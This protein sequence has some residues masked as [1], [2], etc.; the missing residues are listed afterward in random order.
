MAAGTVNISEK[1][2]SKALFR[3]LWPLIIE[4]ILAVTMGAADTVMVSS[5]GEFAVSGINIVDNI[6]NLLIITFTALATGGAVVVSQYI[7]R[8]DSQNASLASRQLVYIVTGISLVIMVFTVFLRRPIISLLYGKI[9]NDVMDAASIYFMITALSYPMLAIYNACAALFRAV[10]NSKVTMRIALL[11]NVMNIGG[12]AF[13]I[14]VL[15]IGVAGAAIS[16]LLCRTVAAAILMGMLIRN[17]R[18]TIT[19]AGLSKVRLIPSMVRNILNVGIPSGIESSMF[20]VGRLLTQRIFTTFGTMAMAANAIA[21]VINSFS[22]MPGTAYGIALL[23]VVG[24]CVGA[25]DY[26]A[27]R[28]QTAKIMKLCYFTIFIMSV[29]IYI[30]MEPLVNLFSLSQ[31]AHDLAKS[32]LRVHC[33][34]MAIGWS[35]SF[36]LPNALRAAGDAKYV[37]LAATVSMWTVRVSFAYILTFAVGLGPVGV[38]LAMGADFVSRGIAYLTR[39]L[40]RRWEGKKVIEDG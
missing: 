14:Y 16:T 4:Q 19:L 2:D 3:L 15:K 11:V 21:G 7:G 6:N 35:M 12:N 28:K 9:E 34:S 24:Q 13:L 36:A 1:W 38:W 33:I 26:G 17:Q 25:G 18:G 40:G 23:T 10:G 39:W 30:F 32:F 22:F 31:E 29:G 5:V 37:M 8:K 27:A 20:Q